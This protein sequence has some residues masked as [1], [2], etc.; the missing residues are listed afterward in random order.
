M[1]HNWFIDFQLKAIGFFRSKVN[2]H[3]Y[4]NSKLRATKCST[5]KVK[6]GKNKEFSIVFAGGFTWNSSTWNLNKIRCRR[7]L[8][9]KN[10]FEK[11]K[12]QVALQLF[13]VFIQVKKMQAQPTNNLWQEK[14]KEKSGNNVAYAQYADNINEIQCTPTLLLLRQVVVIV[15]VGVVV[16][17]I[18]YLHLPCDSLTSQQQGTG[19]QKINWFWLW[20]T[21]V[22]SLP[23]LETFRIVSWPKLSTSPANSEPAL[24]FDLYI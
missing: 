17:Y 1:Q 23:T 22:T 3:S 13:L 6:A 11:H 2:L 18:T 5:A 4:L 21:H 8:K 14:S 10:L 19:Q 20:G 12:E 7:Q 24:T 16:C 9:G 15:V